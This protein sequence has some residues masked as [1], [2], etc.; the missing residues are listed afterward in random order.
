MIVDPASG[1]VYVTRSEANTVDV[2]N[3]VTMA[4]FAA[5]N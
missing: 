3:P 2:F 5:M 4:V 1:L